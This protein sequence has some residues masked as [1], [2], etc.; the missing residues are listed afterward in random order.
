MRKLGLI[1]LSFLFFCGSVFGQNYT[2]KKLE[3]ANLN[4][5]GIPTNER[6]TNCIVTE[7]NV[8]FGATSG[9]RCHLFR[10]DPQSK[11][12]K[13]LAVIEGPNT[14]LKGM[15]LD[16]D[17]IWVGTL[18]TKHQLYLEGKKRGGTYEELDANLYQID[19]T[20]NTGHLYKISGI[21]SDRVVMEDMGIMVKGQGIHT[22]A[23]DPQRGLIYGLTYPLGRFFI[24]DTKTKKTE[25]ITFGTA[26]SFVSNHMVNT[27]KVVK[28]LTDFTVGEVEFNNKLVARAMHVT[29]DG[30]LY[31]SGWDGK[32]IKYDPTIVTPQDRFSVVATIP[33]VAGRQYWNR[34][35]VI[36]EKDGY[37]YMGTSDGYIVRHK[38]GSNKI[39][40]YGKP[41]RAIEV[42]GMSFSPLDGNLYGINGGGLEGVSRFWCLNV[43]DGTFEVDY[44]NIEV[45]DKRPMSDM[46][47]LSNG[48]V[49]MSETERVANLWLFSPGTSR[50]TL[51]SEKMIANP[52][53]DA[54]A[55]KSVAMD[56]FKG[57]KML[58]TDVYPIP[59]EMHGGSGYTAIQADSNG[60]VYIGAAYY[61]KTGT[62]LQLNPVTGRWREI[63]RSDELTHQYARGQ[64]AAGKIH[65]KLRLGSDGKI[66][67]AM[68]QGYEYH[69]KIRSDVGEAPE[70]ERGS[71]IT[72][73]FFS[74]DPKT[75]IARDLGPG[76]LQDGINAFQ[77]DINRG[78]I[79][80]ITEPGR[81]FLVYDLKTDRVWNA[82]QIGT[83]HTYR[84]MA[85]DYATGKIYH[86]G[87]ITPGGKK[88][89]TVW[90]PDK[91]ILE[92]VE[93]AVEGG[94][95]YAHS[96]AWEC[97]S[98]GSHTLY[99]ECDGKIF[100]MDLNTD[101]DGKIHVRPICTAGLEGEII[102]GSPYSFVTGPD[103]R[104]YW[105][106]RYSGFY[107]GRIPMA[108]FAWDPKLQKKT[109]L[110]S[111]AL[112]G[113]WLGG[114]HTQGI[115]FDSEGNLSIKVLYAG[116]NPEQ[117]KLCHLNPGSNYDNIVEQP[118]YLGY[119]RLRPGMYYSV[120]VVRNATRI[121]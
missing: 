40:N 49:V 80:G 119:P 108:V 17:N 21:H 32:L 118:Y 105:V 35:D 33:C 11:T 93:I 100:E 57:H 45:F 120:F 58:E 87:E 19:G 37:L 65:T 51:V 114:G 62:L 7:G 2:Y 66:Y 39:I 64:G 116:I 3:I 34:I 50:D 109:Y 15:V 102:Q 104:I 71:Q 10:Y 36:K 60:M 18:L 89:M 48:T 53:D 16:G 20:W 94:L 61:G 72:C 30:I 98:T 78:Y 59:S 69:Y 26:E 28:D 6:S 14:I 23:I 86:P 81:Y 75:D 97:G 91:F 90:N 5:L 103:G 46:V 22:M 101:R 74:Y 55:V 110:G 24:F 44:P 83:D 79:Y 92:E 85:L 63:F 31:T 96:Y 54:G 113:E 38:I 115:C 9:E 52:S 29:K 25:T 4:D 112:G 67:G 88:Y 106:N 47:C 27:V 73:H 8:V 99:G 70:G 77:V 68:K 41:I 12:L 84:Y 117:W 42:M 56:L 121:K 95:K 111:C 76:K 13:D 43:S 1:L 82:G 107:F